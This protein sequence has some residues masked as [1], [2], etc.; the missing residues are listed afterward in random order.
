MHGDRL[1]GKM[2]PHQSIR[3]KEAGEWGCSPS[4]L[5]PSNMLI[6]NSKHPH[7]RIPGFHLPGWPYNLATWWWSLLVLSVRQGAL[8][9]S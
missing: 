4:L 7:A 2:P 6:P 5:H 8:Y 9:T 1:N 3:N